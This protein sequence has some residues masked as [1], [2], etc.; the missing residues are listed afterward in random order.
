MSAI[1]I[2]EAVLDHPVNKNMT[3]GRQS[4]EE[5][6]GVKNREALLTA[7]AKSRVWVEDLVADRTTI[8]E[9]AKR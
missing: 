4:D 2:S 1:R 7:V 9:I 6:N 3:V 8:A 5:P